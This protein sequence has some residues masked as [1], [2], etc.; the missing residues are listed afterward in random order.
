[1]MIN[2][3]YCIYEKYFKELNTQ[4]KV[5]VLKHVLLAQMGKEYGILEYIN[6]SGGSLHFKLES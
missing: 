4:P 1:M 3:K 2:I 5:S 6:I